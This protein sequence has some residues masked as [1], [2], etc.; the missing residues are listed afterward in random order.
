MNHITAYAILMENP[1]NSRTCYAFNQAQ[2]LIYLSLDQ[3][4]VEETAVMERQ[5]MPGVKVSVVEVRGPPGASLDQI[6]RTMTE[7]WFK[8]LQGAQR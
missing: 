3:W 7:N 4:R 5:Q 6:Q 2:G 8:K 1:E